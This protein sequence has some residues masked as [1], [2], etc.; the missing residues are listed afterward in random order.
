M[1]NFI[2]TA[3]SILMIAMGFG[4]LLMGLVDFTVGEEN[5]SAEGFGTAKNIMEMHEEVEEIKTTTVIGKYAYDVNSKRETLVTLYHYDF[6]TKT[7]FV[8]KFYKTIGNGNG[9]G[10]EYF[11]LN[12]A[13]GNPLFAASP[14]DAKNILKAHLQ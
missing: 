10:Y 11:Q 13:D 7:I 3:A 9:A 1:K 2:G 4:A 5:V 6:P 14:E 12:G 8:E